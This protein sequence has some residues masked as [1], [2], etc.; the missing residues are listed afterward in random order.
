[1]NK[2]DDQEH[3]TDFVVSSF[4]RRLAAVVAEEKLKKVEMVDG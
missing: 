1:M 4:P 3:F 2:E